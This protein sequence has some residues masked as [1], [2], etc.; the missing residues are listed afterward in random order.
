MVQVDRGSIPGRG[1]KIHAPSQLSPLA[2]TREVCAPH[3]RPSTA[4]KNKR[5]KETPPC[6]LGHSRQGS[7]TPSRDIRDKCIP[8]SRQPTSIRSDPAWQADKLLCPGI[9]ALNLPL[10]SR[11]RVSTLAASHL[12]LLRIPK[13][14]HTPDSGSWQAC[15]WVWAPGFRNS[16]G[17][18]NAQPRLR[19]ADLISPRKNKE[20]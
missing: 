12:E 20:K 16:L 1:L 9:I 19:T 10:K 3:R 15:W 7:R 4:P 13:S 6:E 2:S 14:E 17:D 8:R 5:R 18:F 11:A